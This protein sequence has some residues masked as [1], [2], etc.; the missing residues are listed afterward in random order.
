MVFTRSPCLPPS[1][2]VTAEK[3]LIKN[4]KNSP[5]ETLEW[6]IWSFK[7]CPPFVW[8]MEIYENSWAE[9]SRTFPSL[10]VDLRDSHRLL[11]HKL[12]FLSLYFCLF[13]SHGNNRKCSRGYSIHSCL[14]FLFFFGTMSSD[15]NIYQEGSKDSLA[16][17]FPLH[18]VINIRR[19]SWVITFLS[20]FWFL[21]LTLEHGT[22]KCVK[23]NRQKKRW[24]DAHVM[25]GR[26]I[27]TA[28]QTLLLW[29]TH[30]LPCADFGPR[31]R[32]D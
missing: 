7:Y 19:G 12:S 18:C 3:S 6:L 11:S 27:D 30:T 32:L 1:I 16:H 25:V 13:S 21:L 23:Q 26:T 22:E 10:K 17:Y 9:Y 8:F 2:F 14:N 15:V 4:H 31:N 20:P 5:H 24:C 28:T 29:R